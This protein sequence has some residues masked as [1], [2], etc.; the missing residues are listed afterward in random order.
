MNDIDEL[1]QLVI[2]LRFAN[3]TFR[4][5]LKQY[6]SPRCAERNSIRRRR[7]STSLPVWNAE[8]FF[9]RPLPSSA[10][11]SALLRL[12]SMAVTVEL[13]PPVDSSAGTNCVAAFKRRLTRRQ[14]LRTDDGSTRMRKHEHGQIIGVGVGDIEMLAINIHSGGET[15]LIDT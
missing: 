5:F 13:S 11:S 8:F 9:G 7:R 4:K 15:P 10:S 6:S 12:I 2:G 3:E 14:L 1:L